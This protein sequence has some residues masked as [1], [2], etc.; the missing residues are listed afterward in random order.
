MTKNTKTVTVIGSGRSGTHLLGHLIDTSKKVT[1]SIEDRELFPLIVDTVTQRKMENIG[2]IA[3]ILQQRASE[4]PTDIY[5]E[6]S[7]PLLWLAS[8]SAFDDLQVKHIGIVRDPYATVASMLEHKGVR[9]WCEEWDKLPQP[10]IFLGTNN[11]NIED[12]KRMTMAQRCT[13]RWISHTKE[14]IRL[15]YLLPEDKYLL[16]RYED[17][18]NYQKESIKNI[19]KFIG[20]RDIDK[21]YK[22][23]KNSLGKWESNL[24]PNQVKQIGEIIKTYYCE[25]YSE[26]V[27]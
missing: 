14:L 11:Q 18:L 26:S 21:K 4:C 17:L 8:D 9:K 20:V 24:K 3:G 5:L 10:S 25:E 19:E 2:K 6:K 12:Y 22:F 23:N 7:H 13:M 15:T 1:S 16:V 27:F